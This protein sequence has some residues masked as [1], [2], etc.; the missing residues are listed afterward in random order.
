MRLRRFRGYDKNDFVQEIKQFGEKYFNEIFKNQLRRLEL[1]DKKG[2]DGEIIDACVT[3]V[4]RYGLLVEINGIGKAI[5]HNTEMDYGQRNGIKK[6]SVI[7][8]RIIGQNEKGFILSTKN[9]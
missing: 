3:Y 7:K 4:A 2:M 8:A 1:K 6:G 9:L 5:I